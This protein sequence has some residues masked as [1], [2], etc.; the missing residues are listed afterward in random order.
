MEKIKTLSRGDL[1]RFK[2]PII[3]KIGTRTLQN[4]ITKERAFLPVSAVAGVSGQHLLAHVLFRKRFL[5]LTPFNENEGH[6]TLYLYDNYRPEFIGAGY[7][8]QVM[9]LNTLVNVGQVYDIRNLPLEAQKVAAQEIYD[10]QLL[11]TKVFSL[12]GMPPS[13][14]A[15][16]NNS[17]R[18]MIYHDDPG[19]KYALLNIA[20]HSCRDCGV[21]LCH[22][23]T[24][25]IHYDKLNPAAVRRGLERYA[26]STPHRIFPAG[27]LCPNCKGLNILVDFDGNKYKLEFIAIYIGAVGDYLND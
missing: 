19:E 23:K 2:S 25:I 15:A 21:E 10:S 24:Q 9:D 22:R 3:T 14:R 8:I 13:E 4:K 7:V 27:F 18:V 26:R 12:R 20:N 16:F 1:V 6:I 5:C 17:T 11:H